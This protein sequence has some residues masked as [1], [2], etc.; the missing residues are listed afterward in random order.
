MM[1]QFLDE[2]GHF[3]YLI[4]VALEARSALALAAVGAH[5]DVVLGERRLIRD[6][7]SYLTYKYWIVEHNFEFLLATF[8]YCGLHKRLNS[9]GIYLPVF[10]FDLSFALCLSEAQ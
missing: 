1:A 10:K 3:Y 5:L 9:D 6:Y 8:R 4:V 7:T 2:E